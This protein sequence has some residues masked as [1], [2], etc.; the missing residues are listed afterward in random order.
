MGYPDIYD[1]LGLYTST[2]ANGMNIFNNRDIN[3]AK[4]EFAEFLI[5]DIHTVAHRNGKGIGIDKNDHTEEIIK[6]TAKFDELV[7]SML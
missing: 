6:Y 7:R 1:S 2:I 5:D 3:T 4:R